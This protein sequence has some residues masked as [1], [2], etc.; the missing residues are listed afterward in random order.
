[1]NALTRT[2][3]LFMAFLLGVVFLFILTIGVSPSVLTGVL[4]WIGKLGERP[5]D[6]LIAIIIGG[7]GLLGFLVLFA[8]I[9]FTGRLRKARLQKNEIGDINIG[10]GAIESIALNAAKAS[11]SGVKFAK[12]AIGAISGDKLSIR[13]T[14]MTYPDVELPVMMARVQERVK[15]DVE[16]YTGIEVAEVPVRINKVEAMATRVER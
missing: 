12:A 4:D 5:G 9:L 14:I 1:M 13:M 2:L 3:I 7:V 11:Q 10:V 15:K 16:K 8:F 6:R